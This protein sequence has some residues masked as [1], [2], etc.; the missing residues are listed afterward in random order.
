M[1]IGNRE[2]SPGHPCYVIA[3]AG[4]NHSGSLES[5]FRLIDVAVESGADAVK[6][7][8]VQ[9]EQAL[10]TLYERLGFQREGLLRRHTI[11]DGVA[12]DV[13]VMGLL[14]S[15]RTRKP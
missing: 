13:V 10:S 3:E 8:L 2:I 6:F 4:S 14:A 7:Q 12:R 15:E 5:A 9:G 11:K 1:R